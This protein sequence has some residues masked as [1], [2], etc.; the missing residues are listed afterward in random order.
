V[1]LVA[2]ISDIHAKPG[3][4]SLDALA[5]ALDWLSVA[6]PNALILSGDIANPPWAGGY[7][8]VR[9]RLSTV[10]C[11]ILMVPGNKDDRR[12]LRTAFP[13][14]G[15]PDDGPLNIART[16]GDIRVVGLDVTVPGEKYGDAAPVID[17]LRGQLSGGEP[18]LLFMHQHPFRT[19]FARVDNAPCRNAEA[20]EQA[21]LEAPARVMLLSAGHGHRTVFTQ[22]AGVPA[23]MCPSLAKA[24][25]LEFDGDAAPLVDPPG[26]ALH[27]I[28]NGRAMSHVIPL[29]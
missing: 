12:A 16:I 26:F 25:L 2:Q 15:W 4:K 8:L 13:D 21:I 7:P 20:L 6:K 23:M 24:N 9:D 1:T 18:V 29:G 10:K 28:E 11:P 14:A 22:F 3:G 17:W 27:I 19:G 5:R